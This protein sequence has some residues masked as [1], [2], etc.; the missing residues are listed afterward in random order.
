MH[1]IWTSVNSYAEELAE[2]I[3]HMYMK[4]MAEGLDYILFPF[5]AEMK[6]WVGSTKMTDYGNSSCTKF[7]LNNVN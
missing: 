6:S 4:L 7:V 1:C 5:K 3:K 2:G